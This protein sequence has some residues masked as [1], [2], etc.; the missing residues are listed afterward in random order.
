M[1]L[2]LPVPLF[3]CSYLQICSVHR[4]VHF[5][6]FGRCAVIL[7]A[8]VFSVYLFFNAFKFVMVNNDQKG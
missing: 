1:K 5:E 6:L 3:F 4:T 8:I 2:H 7:I